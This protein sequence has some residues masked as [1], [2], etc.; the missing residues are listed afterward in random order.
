MAATGE[1]ILVVESDPDISDLIARQ[2]LKPLGYGVMVVGEAA[3]AIQQAVQMP[4]DLILANLNLLRPPAQRRQRLPGPD[5]RPAGWQRRRHSRRRP[6]RQL[7][8]IRAD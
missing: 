7:H 5:G 4:P 3:S 8:R 6:C 2:A 1:Q